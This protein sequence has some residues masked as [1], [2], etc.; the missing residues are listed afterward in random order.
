MAEIL[1]VS[2]KTLLNII[3][4]R[5]AITPDM[6]FRLSSAFDTTPDLWKAESSADEWLSVKPMPSEQ[7]H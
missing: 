6:A 4:E 2:R 3:N 1:G 7:L 5:G